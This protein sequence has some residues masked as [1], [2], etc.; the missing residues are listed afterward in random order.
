MLSGD[1]FVALSFAFV[2]LLLRKMMCLTIAY[3]DRHMNARLKREEDR[4][5]WRAT[6]RH[7]YCRSSPGGAHQHDPGKRGRAKERNIL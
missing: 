2:S 1:V 4:G 6:R 3:R 7:M 5:G